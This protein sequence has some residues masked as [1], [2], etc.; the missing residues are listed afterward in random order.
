M[1]PQLFVFLVNMHRKLSC[2]ICSWKKKDLH[3]PSFILLG[4]L[5]ASDA[6][7]GL[8]CQPLFAA[9]KIAELEGNFTAFCTLK[10]LQSLSGWTTAGVSFF[11]LA[12]VSID[13]LLKLTLH[14]RYSTIVTVPR[15]FQITL[16][17]WL[18][19]IVLNVL[20]RFWMTR[21]WFF[22]LIVFGSVISFVI[23]VSILK[24]AR[25]VRRHQRQINNQTLAV[26]YLQAN[27][28]NILKSKK[29]A[30]TVLYIYGLFLIFY[31]PFIVLLVMEAFIGFTRRLG[32][33]YDY[34]TTA[35][36]INSFFNPLVYCWR[37]SEI[38]HAVKSMIFRRE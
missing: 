9:H 38:R 14:L 18:I 1:H 19:S 16:A 17:F 30:V 23:M 12:A 32:I 21:I 31:L 7:V 13:R 3:S 29:S 33:A 27:T 37:I 10:I 5:A 36:F 25:I 24:I 2:S 11:I 8:I 6:V 20:L 22:T 26:T 34:A 35:L 15:V 4:C 28:M